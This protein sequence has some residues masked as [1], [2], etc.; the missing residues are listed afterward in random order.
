MLKWIRSRGD[1]LTT[2]FIAGAILM[3]VLQAAGTGGLLIWSVVADLPVQLMFAIGLLAAGGIFL[4]VNQGLKIAKRLSDRSL[5]WATSLD[6]LQPYFSRMSIRLTDLAN[7][8]RVIRGRTFEDCDIYGPGVM[9]PVGVGVFHECTFD[10]PDALIM[11][12][13]SKVIGPIAVEE[14]VFRRC[15]LHGLGLIGSKEKIETWKA[16]GFSIP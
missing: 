5:P 7:P 2:N 11:T 8:N 12:D 10:G 3:G 13:N 15:R 16:A 6:L 9:A 4:L 1:A 14:C